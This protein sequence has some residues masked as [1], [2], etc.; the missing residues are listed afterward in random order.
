MPGFPSSLARRAALAAAAAVLLALAPVA[1]VAALAQEVPPE[2]PA[3]PGPGF[4]SPQAI[5]AAL[6]AGLGEALTGWLRG[7]DL[8][9]AIGA[10]AGEFL[11]WALRRVWGGLAWAFGGA[12]VFTSLPPAWTTELPAVRLARE[13]LTPVATAVVGLGLALS[14]LLAG[15]GTVIGRPFGWLWGRL[16]AVLLATA[17]LAVAPQ[18]IAWYFRLCNA[19]AGAVLDPF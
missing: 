14:V 18:L 2:P 10:A 13:R 7:P 9:G 4:P 15:L 1:A 19:L 11:E 5:A 8:R 16:G 12:N 3:A 6:L 17:G